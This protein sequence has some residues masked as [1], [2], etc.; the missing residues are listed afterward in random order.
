[1]AREPIL[2][3]AHDPPLLPGWYRPGGIVGRLAPLHLDEGDAPALE[4]DESISPT[5]VL[6]RYA[7]MQ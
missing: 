6:Q 7:T 3:G 1:V 5:G 2:G 4:R